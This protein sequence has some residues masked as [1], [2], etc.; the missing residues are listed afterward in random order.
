MQKELQSNL[1]RAKS[2][3]TFR[4]HQ[5]SRRDRSECTRSCSSTPPTDS[6]NSNTTPS[7]RLNFQFQ[8]DNLFARSAAW[9]DPSLD[10]C[11]PRAF[12]DWGQFDSLILLLKTADV[13]Q[14]NSLAR[15][16]AYFWAFDLEA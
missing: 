16:K 8:Q 14:E 4:D 1:D 3:P 10:Y 5:A 7:K 9:L 15:T 2:C 6:D 12:L 13:V 11:K